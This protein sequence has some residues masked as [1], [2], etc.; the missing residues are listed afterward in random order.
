MGA[1]KSWRTALLLSLLSTAA[2]SQVRPEVNLS[3][4]VPDVRE[5]A[6]PATTISGQLSLAHA[7]QRA[8]DYKAA[9]DILL[10]ALSSA[11]TST[12]LLDALGS[13]AQD[14]G[15]YLEAERF[16]LEAL[17]DAERTNG[18]PERIAILNNLGTLY[19]DTDQYS[20]GERIRQ[21]LESLD[22]GALEHHPTEAAAFLDVIASLEH[23]RKRNDEARR[24]YARSLV[25]LRMAEGSVSVDAAL[26]E[27][28]LA[29]LLLDDQRYQSATARFRQA[30]H[31]IEVA[32]SPQNPALIRPLINL[33]RADN[34]GGHAD[35][36]EP[37]ARR[38]VELSLKTFGEGH[39][40][41]A[42]AMLEHASSLRRLRR[43]EEARDLEKRARTWL[44]GNADRNLAGYTVSLRD[45]AGAGIR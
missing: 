10:Q 12:A 35:Q 2:M 40:A 16:Y 4:I 30:I 32:S 24:Y 37:A 26:V 34:L 38:A 15:N 5:E 21:K 14:S 44:K 13:V 42:A 29:F 28:N 3:L 39:P 36:A 33:A 1:K 8:G 20:K 11:P 45:L 31:E 25:L 7:K 41:T 43:K 23:A 9:R 22:F 18:D 17:D 19:L 6:K 27:A